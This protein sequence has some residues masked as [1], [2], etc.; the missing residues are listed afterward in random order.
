[1]DDP[2]FHLEGVV[3]TKDEF[4][5]FDGPLNL[6]L[7]LLS[8]NKIEIRDISI[9]TLLEQYLAYLDDMAKM[10]L[11]IASEFVS[12]ASHLM[13]IKT[14]VLL[15]GDE[16]VSEL[17]QLM[18]SLEK[19][20]AKDV[21]GQIKG[22]TDEFARMFRRGSGLIAKPQ[23]TVPVNK[24]YRY[25]HDKQDILDALMRVMNREDL[26]PVIISQM[27]IPKRIVYSIDK[28]SSELVEKLR[29][30]GAVRVK[31]LF[32][33]CASRSEMVATFL[34]ILELC[35]SGNVLI[36]GASDDLTIT[37][38]QNTGADVTG[39]EQDGQP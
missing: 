1:M 27:P 32:C 15:S 10:D 36:A 35:R 21:N 19:L 9:S 26:P 34:V 2:I 20:R 16:E 38:C 18:D 12:M 37:Y 14:K 6:I 3:K 17:E 31:K 11:E 33:E 29:L 23:E 4:E 5:D 39:D 8:K 22:V 13:Y 28:K 25:N 30:S 7:L 24:E